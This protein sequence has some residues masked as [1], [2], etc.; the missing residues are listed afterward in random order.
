MPKYS[1]LITKQD[2]IRNLGACTRNDKTFRVNVEAYLDHA[3]NFRIGPINEFF[4]K[5][6]LPSI[7][8][9]LRKSKAFAE[10]MG[11]TKPELN[12]QQD[13]DDVVFEVLEEIASRRNEIA[14]GMPSEILSVS[15][16]RGLSDFVEVFAIGL[17]SIL[18]EQALRYD[19]KHRAIALKKAIKVIDHRILCVNLE[20]Q[21]IALG[22]VIIAVTGN[23]P[24]GYRRGRILSLEING[25]AMKV[26]RRKPSIDV[27]IAVDCRIK[28][29]YDFF[30]LR[31]SKL[32]R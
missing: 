27:G 10:Y 2:I 25:R 22:D 20:N 14:H 13:G 30:L 28:P 21:T 15:L 17:H 18:V 26:V 4:G 1:N 23:K 8:G 3:A 6:G 16:L 24:A 5:V 29:S 9:E 12:L 19:V 11:A 7:S 32:P 31:R